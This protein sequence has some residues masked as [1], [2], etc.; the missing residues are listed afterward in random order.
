M[1]PCG[2]PSRFPYFNST[3]CFRRRRFR[4][5]TLRGEPR[6]GRKE[7]GKGWSWYLKAGNSL[8]ESLETSFNSLENQF[9]LNWTNFYSLSRYNSHIFSLLIPP[10]RF[11]IFSLTG[12]I[13]KFKY[14]E[15]EITNTSFKFSSRDHREYLTLILIHMFIRRKC[16]WRHELRSVLCA[17][18][19][20]YKQLTDSCFKKC[21]LYIVKWS[22]SHIKIYNCIRGSQNI[23]VAAYFWVWSMTSHFYLEIKND[24]LI[25]IDLT[26]R[27]WLNM[28]FSST[29][30]A[31]IFTKKTNLY[32]FIYEDITFSYIN[33]LFFIVSL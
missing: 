17:V 5:R 13:K 1:L 21:C 29:S 11:K 26:C 33:G 20:K 27:N 22:F 10:T 9:C 30:F 23:N 14:Y 12:P 28:T 24:H 32:C 16:T 19:N 31:E 7:I 25:T 18:D 15:N 6:R 3:V 4:R 2:W 8:K